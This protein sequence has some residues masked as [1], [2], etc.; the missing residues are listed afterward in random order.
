[1]MIVEAWVQNRSLH[2]GETALRL[3]DNYPITNLIHKDLSL[4]QWTQT[5]TSQC[6]GVDILWQSSIEL[7]DF[8]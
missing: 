6:I 7:Y 8:R 2:T 5:Y 4:L 1:M 3:H